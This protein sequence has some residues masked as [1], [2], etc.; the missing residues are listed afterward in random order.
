VP[1]RILGTEQSVS[2]CL[3][4]RAS[5]SRVHES[6]QPMTGAMLQLG[7]SWRMNTPHSTRWLS[8]YTQSGMASVG[9]VKAKGADLQNR[10][11]PS[12]RVPRSY[13]TGTGT[14]Q[15]IVGN[16]RWAA[17]YGQSAP[18]LVRRMRGHS[19]GL[20]L[21]P[22]RPVRSGPARRYG[23]RQAPYG[24]RRLAL[25]VS[26]WVSHD[27]R[28]ILGPTVTTPMPRTPRECYLVS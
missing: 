27:T 8:V 2:D 22:C 7:L 3:P 14:R 12:A 16:P 15:W 26:V 1:R 11:K 10:R 24:V 20:L 5:P 23:L 18:S 4:S 13:P 21:G 25:R 9:G 28:F 17:H 19:R 6:P